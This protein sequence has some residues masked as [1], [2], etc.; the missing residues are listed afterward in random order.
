LS[1]LRSHLSSVK[2]MADLEVLADAACLVVLP[3]EPTAPGIRP[4]TALG[5]PNVMAPGA[6]D[7]LFSAVKAPPL[8]VRD[9]S[10]DERSPSAP[11]SH[12]PLK[13]NGVATTSPSHPPAIVSHVA[14]APLGPFTA[15]LR[16]MQATSEMVQPTLSITTPQQQ[17]HPPPL[18]MTHTESDTPTLLAHPSNSDEDK[19]EGTEEPAAGDKLD[20]PCSACRLSRVRCNRMFPCS[21]CTRLGLECKQPRKV[22]RGRP[23]HKARLA[24][25]QLQARQHDSTNLSPHYRAG[26]S[27]HLIAHLQHTRH[28]ASH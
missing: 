17:L 2:E 9:P 24:R 3:S 22:Q 27:A 25:A 5:Q 10:A 19:D 13:L 4:I 6:G 1:E 20:R 16:M 7:V 11:T 18:P 23:S 14:S 8:M 28:A 15:T 12:G 26:S 21:R